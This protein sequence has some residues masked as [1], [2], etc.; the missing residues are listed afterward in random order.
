MR[1]P[2]APERDPRDENGRTTSRTRS[3]PPRRLVAGVE[4]WREGTVHAKR[5]SRSL[6]W[7][8]EPLSPDVVPPFELDVR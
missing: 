5:E 7:E 3:Q 2:T 8:T 6:S 1:V 4:V